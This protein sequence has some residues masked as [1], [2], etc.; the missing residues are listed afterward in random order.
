VYLWNVFLKILFCHR[1]SRTFELEKIQK[2]DICGKNKWQRIVFAEMEKFVEIL[3][4]LWNR[5]H[6]CSF[7]FE[8]L[9]KFWLF[10]F[11]FDNMGSF[12]Q[13]W[14]FFKIWAKVERKVDERHLGI[15]TSLQENSNP[16]DEFLN[17]EQ[18]CLETMIRQSIADPSSISAVQQESSWNIK[19][20]RW[21]S[22]E[23]L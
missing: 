22:R 20:N 2:L 7:T 4:T 19:P 5:C 21:R 14:S 1:H 10:L 16:S 8:G 13:V 9:C 17:I 15:W 18:N 3:K 23:E 6:A 12:A 11:Y